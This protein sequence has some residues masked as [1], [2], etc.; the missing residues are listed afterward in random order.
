[1]CIT[2][3]LDCA[4]LYAAVAGGV[5]I[6][7][8]ILHAGVCLL[9]ASLAGAQI[10]P[11]GAV[12][13][14]GPGLH[15]N[16]PVGYSVIQLTPS[17]ALV[18]LLAL[19]ECP[20]IEGAQH[21]SE[22]LNATIVSAEGVPM[23]HFPRDFSFRITASLRKTVLDPPERTVV[24]PEEPRQFLLRL[25]FRLKIYDGLN[26][27]EVQPKTVTLIGVPADVSYDERVFRLTF[28]VGELPLSDRLVL[29][30][31]SPQ[32][33]TLTHFCFGLL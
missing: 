27:R 32:G 29:E 5:A 24:T 33:E 25:G 31:L 17:G 10:T 6:R 18:S 20:E 2:P 30:A 16:T 19:I 26:M 11:R 4:S 22:G 28:D 12:T 14:S 15:A 3:R 13:I 23:E 8:S 1:L 21:V 7:S 9:A